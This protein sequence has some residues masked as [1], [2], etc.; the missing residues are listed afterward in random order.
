MTTMPS[1]I[2]RTS[3]LDQLEAWY[4]RNYTLEDLSFAVPRITRAAIKL[5]EVTTRTAEEY[6]KTVLF[7]LEARKEAEEDIE[8]E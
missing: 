8:L 1:T 6:G 2:E 7:R 5:F 3:R 4:L